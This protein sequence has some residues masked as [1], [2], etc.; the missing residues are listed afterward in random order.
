VVVR[1]KDGRVA[2]WKG[3]VRDWS[4]REEAEGEVRERLVNGV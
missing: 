3:A 4:L 2:D 1:I